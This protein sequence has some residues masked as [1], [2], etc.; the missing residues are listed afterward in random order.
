MFN[1]PLHRAGAAGVC[2]ALSLFSRI[3][4]ADP[5]ADP[6]DP[7][8]PAAEAETPAPE[9]ANP[10]SPP[11]AEPNSDRSAPSEVVVRGTPP[12]RSASDAMLDRPLLEAAPHK[13]ASELLLVVPGVFVSQHGG[14][15]KAHQIF[16]R[17]FDAVHGQDVEFWAGGAPVNEVSNIH[18]QGYADLN[19]LIPEV[20]REVHSLPGTYDPRQGDFAV[21][22]SVDFTLGYAEPGVT[23]KVS[24]GDSGTH[25]YFLAYH[26]EG[27]DPAT[28]GA[29][30]LYDTDGFGPSRA[31]RRTSA[32]G[33]ATY[34]FGHGIG[35]RIQASTYAARFDS[36]GVLRLDDIESG[37]VDRFATYDPKQG[38][39]SS[40]TQVV[41]E[42]G[43]QAPRGDGE[44][45]T[46]AVSPFVVLRSLRLRSDFTGY[47]T[48]PEGDSIQQL[49]EATTFGA[50]AHYR[51]VLKLTSSHDALEA[52][53]LL[54]SDSIHQTQHRL[55]LLDDRVTDDP[56][57]PGVDADVRATNAA[58]Y[59]DAALFP[60]RRVRLRG[61]LRVDGLSYS[62][63]DEGGQ[64]S[65]QVR[66]AL[67]AQFSPRGTLEV[68]P[69]SGFSAVASA[70]QGFR[71]PQARSLGDGETTPFT[72]VTSYEAGAR[73]A[74]GQRFR[75]SLALYHT[76]L[77]DDLVF[78]P[79]TARNELVPA[80]SRTGVA[81]N[82][83]ARPVPW[84]LSSTSF[85]YSVARFE[86]DGNGYH[87][88]DRVPYVPDLV[89]RSDLA[90]TPELGTIVGRT[91]NSHFGTGLTYFGRRP[92]PYGQ[93]GHDA[94]LIDASASLRLGPVET[95]IEIYNLLDA[96]WFDGEFVYASA[97]GG[98]ES[99]VPERHVTVGPPRTFLWSLS[100]FI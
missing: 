10:T 100:L 66:S 52:G 85:T 84:L 99:L 69:F 71:S 27:A 90:L 6:R 55:S 60:I 73:Y 16:F 17:G 54:R 88:G 87:T 63:E 37:N 89:V 49:N 94:F 46:W 47:L 44:P 36:A 79:T 24:L 35:G 13:N 42:L 20:V 95:G 58:G 80:T 57:S 68:V 39:N 67:G 78:D 1:R 19:F 3:L 22:G 43:N 7:S 5:S 59:I 53:L 25:R 12:P 14:E 2:A 45:D 70:G 23:G 33:Q 98:Q 50:R 29:F 62:T 28:F 21:A 75:S 32:I 92:L 11:P 93:F 48:S 31:A 18:G 91:L 65:G 38:G 34:D 41:L 81:A 15:G 8:A 51:R 56:Q 72:R 30:E 74:D 77:S 86:A 26:P 9:T 64:S 61:G 76:R 82:L 97:F 83:G 40:R 4:R 96:E